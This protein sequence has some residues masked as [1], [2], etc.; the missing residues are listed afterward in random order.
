[1]R[2]PRPHSLL[3]LPRHRPAAPT[4]RRAP[5]WGPGASGGAGRL[6][7]GRETEGHLP[8]AACP[9]NGFAGSGILPLTASEIFSISRRG[10][11]AD[12]Q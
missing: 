2:G 1:M 7:S 11:T 4:A 8:A 9:A 12:N 6:S 10:L 3:C 5:V